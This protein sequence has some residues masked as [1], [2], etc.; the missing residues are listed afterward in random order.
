M[1]G[2]IL[3]VTFILTF[4]SAAWMPAAAFE[5]QGTSTLPSSSLGK[6]TTGV[7]REI[8]Y[9]NLVFV[10]FGSRSSS[11]ALQLM[12]SN[13]PMACE[14]SSL[15]VK[16]QYSVPSIVMNKSDS[17]VIRQFGTSG[18]KILLVTTRNGAASLIQITD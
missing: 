5:Q 2:F 6:G 9:K 8:C 7:L 17:G 12:Q 4:I 16:K 3:Y 14:N 13:K 1:P 11:A 18:Q 10:T 15:T